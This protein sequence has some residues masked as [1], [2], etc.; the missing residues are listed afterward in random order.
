[1]GLSL[2]PCHGT[3]HAEAI[4]Q[5]KFDSAICHGHLS[6][7]WTSIF[8]HTKM[9]QHGKAKRQKR[10][11]YSNPFE[12][13]IVD[14]PFLLGLYI[15]CGCSFTQSC[16][17]KL[18]PG[19]SKSQS[20]RASAIMKKILKET[21][22]KVLSMGYDYIDNIGFHSIW[23][24][25]STY[26][27]S[28]PGGPSPAALCLRGGWS[29]GQVKD[30]YFHQTQGGDESTV[31]CS[32]LL[33]MMNGEFASSPAFFD[34]GVDAN[35]MTET[36]GK[37]FPNFQSVVGMDR[38]LRISLASLIHHREKVMAFDANHIAR[39]ILIFRDLSTIETVFDKIEVVQAWDSRLHLVTGVPPHIKELVDL[40]AL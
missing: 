6:I 39:S 25:V 30:I 9:Q 27:A 35:W 36:I 13:Y 8:K 3:W 23:K 32:T 16:S 38:I 18:F 14:I 7:I 24:G 20:D 17:R 31:R 10:A 22:Q 4:T 28:L 5:Q 15:S 29:M 12:H 33:N 21:E 26:L 11:V 34:D 19:S 1:L 40:E 37:V 2:L